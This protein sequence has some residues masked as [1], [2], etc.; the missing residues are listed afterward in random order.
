MNIMQILQ[1]VLTYFLTAGFMAAVGYFAH[2]S[3]RVT[4]LEEH[5][6][7]QMKAVEKVDTLSEKLTRIDTKLD[8]LLEGKIINKEGKN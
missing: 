2:L 4:I 6:K 8:L 7:E 1:T 5:D 3:K